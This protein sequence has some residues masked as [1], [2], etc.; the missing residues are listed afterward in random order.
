VCVYILKYEIERRA[1]RIRYSSIIVTRRMIFLYFKNIFE[2]VLI[3]FFK[4]IF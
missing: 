2:G 4:L 1:T 3:C